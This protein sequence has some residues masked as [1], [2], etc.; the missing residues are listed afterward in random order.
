M[1]LP[2]NPPLSQPIRQGADDPRVT[3]EMRQAAK[4]LESVFTSEMMKAMRNTIEESEFSLNNS[5]TEIYQGML[6]QEYADI[7][8]NQNSLGL[9]RQIIDYWLRSMPQEQYNKNRN[10][11]GPVTESPTVQART[12]GTNE[13]QSK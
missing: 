10:S 11:Q 13:G 1:K 5:A 6:D 4:N 2:P 8:A 3:P 9:S 7:A 12:G